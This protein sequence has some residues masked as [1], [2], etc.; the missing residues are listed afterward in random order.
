MSN[1][2]AAIIS[3]L[4]AVIVVIGFVEL[5][6]YSK[7]AVA[8]LDEDEE[9]LRGLF[10]EL[11]TRMREGGE[12]TSE[13]LERIRE[14]ANDGPLER[15]WRRSR[16]PIVVGMWWSVVCAALVSAE[17]LVILWAAID[18]H[19]PAQWVAWY[20]LLSSGV[21]VLT[22][23]ALSMRRALAVPVK[24]AAPFQSRREMLALRRYI[25]LAFQQE[26][27]ERDSGV[28]EGAER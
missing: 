19:G 14:M 11:L 16:G 27:V 24:L 20:S 1:D 17:L 10:E 2:Y 6:A 25:R 21:G 13:Q 8:G 28:V 9:S 12:P 4:I 26:E 22:L 3:A 5:E 15:S 18:K 23:M 7:A